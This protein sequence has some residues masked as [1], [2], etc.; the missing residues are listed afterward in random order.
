MALAGAWVVSFIIFTANRLLKVFWSKLDLR[1]DWT[2][3]S[4]EKP[5]SAS[6]LEG[7]IDNTRLTTANSLYWEALL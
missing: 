1:F 5:C 3:L 6:A 7:G 4:C 2:S